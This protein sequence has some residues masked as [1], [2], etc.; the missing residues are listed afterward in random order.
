MSEIKRR[1]TE[2]LEQDDRITGVDKWELETGRN[3]VRVAFT[4]HS[5]YGDVDV[6]KEVE[7]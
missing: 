6:E 4:V 5:I 3:S 7:I 1:I 2:A